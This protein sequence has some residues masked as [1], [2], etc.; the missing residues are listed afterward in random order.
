M[1]VINNESVYVKLN[2]KWSNFKD[3]IINNSEMKE[4]LINAMTKK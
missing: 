4:L 1:G 3:E 2:S